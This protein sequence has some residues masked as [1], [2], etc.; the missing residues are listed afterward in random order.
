MRGVK[1]HALILAL[2]LMVAGF[3]ATAYQIMVL[4]IPMSESETDPVWVIDARLSFRASGNTPVKAQLFV[5]PPS[6]RYL[7]L[8]ESFISQNYGFNVS[9]VDANRQVTWSS[10]RAQGEQTLYY[11]K[12]LSQRFGESRL[13]EAGPQFRPRPPLEGPERIAAEALLAPIRQH[14]A[15]VETFISETVRRVNN[16]NDDNVRLLLGSD[17]SIS[18]R[19]RVVEKLLAVAHI[20]VQQV[21]TIRLMASQ[22]QTPE[23]WLRSYNGERWIYFNPVSGDRGLPDDRIVWW[24]GAVPVADQ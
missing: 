12:T 1:L 13:V 8:N 23:Q 5:P 2:V 18:N 17:D 21:H 16:L 14:S 19:T 22:N 6:D 9:R 3:G 11:R 7:V 10:R 20:P 15:D 24:I 4:N